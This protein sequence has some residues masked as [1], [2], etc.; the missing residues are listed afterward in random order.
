M[1]LLLVAPQA[2]GD[3]TG[4]SWIAFQWLRRLSE[5][6]DV[7]VLSYYPRDGRLLAPQ[8]PHARVIE[9]PEPPFIGLHERFTSMLKPGNEVFR[10]R[11]HRWLR[12]ALAAGETFDLGHQI[13]PVSL[14]YSSPLVGTGL[15]FVIGPVGGSLVSPRAFVAEEGGAPWYTSLRALDTFRLRH[16]PVLRRTFEEAECVLGIADYVRELL[17]DLQLRD[18][19]LLGDMGLDGLAEPA[20]GSDRTTGVRLLFVGRVIRTKGVRD[21]IR[22]LSHLPEGLAVLDVVGQG[23]DQAACQELATDLG[24]RGA[25]RFHGLVPHS[26]VADYYVNADIFMFPSYR[27]AGGIVVVEA[28]SHGLP[29]IV[30]DRGG[31]ASSVDDSCGIRVAAHGPDQY[32]RDLAQAVCAL[33]TDP[34]RRRRAGEAAR[35]RVERLILW[36]RRIEFIESLYEEILR[37]RGSC[38]NPT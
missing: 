23:Y 34:E 9:W 13:V 18:F 27:E 4:E 30:C 2:D 31:P 29:A 8:L 37:R 33:A 35:R 32:G 3:T 20:P 26:E 15:P 12:R 28:M 1:K 7:T 24:V 22:A 38:R 21:A 17:G 5:R 6:H 36:D 25:V 14:R 16:D 19:R 11:A 10:R